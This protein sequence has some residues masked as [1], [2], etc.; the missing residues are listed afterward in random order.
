MTLDN[1]R[2]IVI[3]MPSVSWPSAGKPASGGL[4]AGL[5]YGQFTADKS[6]LVID[7]AGPVKV[8]NSFCSIRRR[9]F[10]TG[11]LSIW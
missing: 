11:W 7:A 10:R 8:A 2:R 9:A 4:V 3:D 6:R 1:P 5:R